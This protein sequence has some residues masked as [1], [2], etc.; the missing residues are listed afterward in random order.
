MEEADATCHG[1]AQ[2]ED[3]AAAAC[4]QAHIGMRLVHAH[5]RFR[6]AVTGQQRAVGLVCPT[7]QTTRRPWR[8]EE[9]AAPPACVE[10]ASGVDA[11]GRGGGSGPGVDGWVRFHRS[12]IGEE[13][14]A[15]VRREGNVN[16]RARRDRARVAACEKKP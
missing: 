16:G 6:R 13:A 3:G 2:E 5:V 14:A 4:E 15:V 7:L 10:E 9:E 1:P 12:R 11:S 8:P